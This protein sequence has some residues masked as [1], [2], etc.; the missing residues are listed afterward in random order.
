[1]PNG[2]SD[3]TWRIE[4]DQIALAFVVNKIS[5]RRGAEV[6]KPLYQMFKSWV[7]TDQGTWDECADMRV[8]LSKK[9]GEVIYSHDLRTPLDEAQ[10]KRWEEMC[11]RP[12]NRAY[13]MDRSTL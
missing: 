10:R 5:Q 9:K 13:P 3:I 2:A 4:K 8:S 6:I 7:R 11:A 1:L 12:G